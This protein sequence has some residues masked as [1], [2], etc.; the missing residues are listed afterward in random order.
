VSREKFGHPP[1][2]SDYQRYGEYGPET[3]RRRSK[4]K[5]WADAVAANSDL[6]PEE[7]K[8]RQQKGGCYRTTEEWLLKLRKL[9]DRIGHAP[10]TREANNADINPN[11]LCLRVKE[12]W[13][14]VLIAA[15]VDIRSRSKQAMLLSTSTERLIDD[16]FA[17]SVR[18][19]HPA[20]VWEYAKTGHYPYT[21]V[22]GRLGGWRKVKQ[23]VSDRQHNKYNR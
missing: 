23:I 21:T 3:V 7:I 9:A 13:T 14:Q 1:T 16:V 10:T 11:Q 6:D 8:Y 15:S 4:K 5:Y 19:G 12:N 18:L 22:R 20:K 2:R 17:V